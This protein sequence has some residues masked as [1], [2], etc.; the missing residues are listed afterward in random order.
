LVDF[1]RISRDQLDRAWQLRPGEQWRDCELCGS[2]F[3]AKRSHARYCSPECRQRAYRENNLFA[4]LTLNLDIE[5]D[6]VLR[7][8][9]E[10][11]GVSRQHVVQGLIREFVE[12]VEQAQVGHPQC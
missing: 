7:D 12:F 3:R 1:Q 5:S 10:A 9:A 11:N 2:R 8:I 6:M 4:T